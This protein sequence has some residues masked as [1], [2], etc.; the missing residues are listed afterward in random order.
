MCF[1][2]LDCDIF[3]FYECYTGFGGVVELEHEFAVIVSCSFDFLDLFGGFVDDFFL[4]HG[5]SDD[6]G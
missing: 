1:D 2:V 6:C 3:K 5:V 4:G